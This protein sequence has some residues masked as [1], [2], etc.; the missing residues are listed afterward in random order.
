MAEATLADF[1]T[2]PRRD[3]LALPLTK[4]SSTG[5]IA[6][7]GTLLEDPAWIKIATE[8]Q[9]TIYDYF[10]KDASTGQAR[11]LAMP[12]TNLQRVV[13]KTAIDGHA[14]AM[15]MLL[16]FATKKCGLESTDALTYWTVSQTVRAGQA[17]VLDVLIRADPT[18]L[19]QEMKYSG[20]PLDEAFNRRKW[21]VVTVLLEHGID[22]RTLRKRPDYFS[23]RKH[24]LSLAPQAG[25]TRMAELLL[26]Q[27]FPVK[28]SGALHSAAEL[29]RLDIMLLLLEH[30]ADVN[31]LLC[32][33]GL[34][35][36]EDKPLFASWTP[37]HFAVSGG[38]LDAMEL[39]QRHGAHL[40]V[41]DKNG[42]TAAQLLN[43]R[44]QAD[45][46]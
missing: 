38:Q 39:L 29:G 2:R 37:L 34:I 16:E 21:E 4:A 22:A 35:M 10:D 25:G 12:Y 28:G 5:D 27:K 42:K 8:E 43:E 18:I 46:S 15:S 23:Y 26:A 20:L 30:H 33:Q 17:A 36:A 9:H 14:K 6:A 19:T 3:D 41:R 1:K 44:K 7:L 24:P 11:V 31:E 13:L 32:E 45:D 40:N